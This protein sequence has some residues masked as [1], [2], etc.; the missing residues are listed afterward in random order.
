MRARADLGVERRVLMRVLAVGE[1]EELLVGLDPVAREDLVALPEPAADRG[2]V[3]RRLGERLV[4]EPVPR[5]DRDL[6]A[7]LLELGEHGV[8]ALGL[9]HDRHVAVV[10]GRR[11]DHRRPSDV[12][13]LERLVL[14]HVEARD[15]ALERVEV[16]AHEVD[17]L[18]P[19]LLERLEVSGVV[20]DGEQRRVELRDAAS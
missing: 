19:L 16:H 4:G 11:A 18:D 9:D 17:L 10:L 2:V 12:D 6:P 7:R 20:A 13:V 5:L 15:G 3:A 1:V 8:V 14:A